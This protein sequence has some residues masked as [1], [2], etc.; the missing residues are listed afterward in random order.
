MTRQRSRGSGWK[1]AEWLL[2]VFGAV[3]L[4]LGL[5]TAFGPADEYIGIG[6]DWSWRVGDVSDGWIYGM[7]ALGAMLL[8]GLG[9]MM[10]AGRQREAIEPTPFEDL[11]WHAGVFTLV[12]AFVWAQDLALGSGLDYALWLTIPWA[13]GLGLHAYAASRTR[14]ELP[15]I[16]DPVPG[17][18]LQRH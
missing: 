15:T 3:A 7:V 4:F 9:W 11:V 8:L 13:I 2:G 5:F 10:L 17:R 6:G 18:Q 16:E 14:P 12:N 1:A